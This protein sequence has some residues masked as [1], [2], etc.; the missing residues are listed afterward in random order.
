MVLWNII[1]TRNTTE[2]FVE[3]MKQF[4]RFIK[5]LGCVIWDENKIWIIFSENLIFNNNYWVKLQKKM[6]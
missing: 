1:P 3:Q 6:E 4:N 5:A 2:G